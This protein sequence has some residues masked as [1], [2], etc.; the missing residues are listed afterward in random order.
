[1][2]III[3]VIFMGHIFRELHEIPIPQGAYINHSDARVFL[4]SDD[5]TGRQKRQVIGIATSDKTMHPNTM[6]R[7]LYPELWARY[8]GEHNLPEH[9]LHAGIY[10]ALLGIGYKTGMYQILHQ[11]YGPMYGNGIMDYCMYS[12]LN[13]TNTSQL[14]SECMADQVKFSDTTHDDWWFS[15]LFKHHMSANANHQLRISW[16]KKCAANGTTKAWICIDGSNNDIALSDSIF[17]EK[18]KAKSGMNSNLVSFIWAVSA[19]DG[20]PLTYFVNNG[21]MADS[22]AFQTIIAFLQSAGIETAGVI[23]DRGFCNH[24]VISTIEK[25]GYKYVVMLKSNTTAHGQ[26]FEDHSETIR[27]KTKYVINDKGIFGTIQKCKLFSLHPETAKVGLFYDGINGGER[28]VRL[29]KK[30]LAAKRDA[31]EMIRNGKKPTVPSKFASFFT[32]EQSEGNWT[33]SYNYDTWQTALDGKGFYSI[34][35]NADIDASELYRTYYLRDASEKQFMSMKSQL[36]FDTTRVHSDQSVESKFAVCFVAAVIRSEIM[37][38]CKMLNADTNTVIQNL[39]RISFVLMVDGI[40]RA[41]NNISLKQQE[42][43]SQF[44]IK[45]SYFSAFADDVNR[46]MNNPINSQIHRLPDDSDMRSQR[47]KRGRPPKEKTAVDESAP[48]RKPGRPK[49]SKNQKTI[50]KEQ[51]ALSGEISKRKPGRPKG[52]KNKPKITVEKRSPGRPRKTP[53]Q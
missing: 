6:F 5:G 28:S 24:E 4:I 1:M 46:R 25:L 29:I 42:I 2:V 20:T 8:Y 22:K 9:E 10:A 47:K 7:F 17:A 21:G 19:G 34:A 27:W 37:K 13:R 52:S 12:I 41:V 44:G 40:Y 15:S 3:E 43:L 53:K 18:G 50:Q 36:G 26:M 45:T 39:N 35:T 49:G 30:V 23:L 11:I 33:I 38:A 31:E 32:I 16:L 14:F 51:E 48:K